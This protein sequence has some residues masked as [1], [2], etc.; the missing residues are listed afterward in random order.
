MFVARFALIF[1]AASAA[2]FTAGGQETVSVSSSIS[3][4]IVY[5]DRALVTRAANASLPAGSSIIE[6]AGLPATLDEGS[7][8]VSGKSDGTLTIEGIDIR[9]Q[10]LTDRKE[11]EERKYQLTLQNFRPGPI[12]LLVYDQIPVSK[13]TEIV[14]N[15]GAFSD[16]PAAVDKDTGKLSWEIELPPRVKK[17]IQ[18]GYSVEWPKGKKVSGTL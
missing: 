16:N 6:F 10:F 11:V 12:R 7:V 9:Q 4:V 2:I 5:L 13:N 3:R 15:Q 1:V 17:V 18:F 8:A 14:V